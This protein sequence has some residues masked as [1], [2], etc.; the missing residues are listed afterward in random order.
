MWLVYVCICAGVYAQC[1][2]LYLCV[3][4]F[5]MHAAHNDLTCLFP[6][7]LIQVYFNYAVLKQDLYPSVPDKFSAAHPMDFLRTH[8]SPVSHSHVE[9][10]GPFIM[11]H[12]HT[13]TH[14]HTHIHTCTCSCTRTCTQICTHQVKVPARALVRAKVQMAWAPTML[15]HTHTCDHTHT[16]TQTHAHTYRMKV[17]ARALVRAK[18]QMAWALTMLLH[19]YGRDYTH[20]H[21]HTHTH[22]YLQD[23][24][25]STSA[26]E[27]KG[28]NGVG[29]DFAFTYIQT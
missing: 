29:A 25:A 17:P 18:V 22:S 3:S 7:T 23:E 19:T 16:H 13:H 28:A 5:L 11:T 6:T 21:T 15:T 26:G 2:T 1:A 14:M 8:T 12:A 20:I 24:G 10:L 4:A 9:R 27:G